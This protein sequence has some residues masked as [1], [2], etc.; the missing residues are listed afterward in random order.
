MG[1]L[2]L[3]LAAATFLI[4]ASAAIPSSAATLFLDVNMTGMPFE[5]ALQANVAQGLCNRGKDCG[6]EACVWL[7]GV[8]EGLPAGSSEANGSAFPGNRFIEWKTGH[9]GGPW[10]SSFGECRACKGLR[11]R[12]L[13]TAA[14][15]AGVAPTPTTFAQLLALA[16]PLLKGRVRYSMDEMH[17]LGPAVTMSGTESALPVTTQH[18]PF[19]ELPLLLDTTGKFADATDATVYTA[20]HLLAKT[21]TSVLAVQ[22][23]TDMP[24]LVDAIVESKMAVFWMHD[25]CSRNQSNVG[26]QAQ[27][28]AMEALL[29]GGHFDKLGL[30][31]MGWF[32]AS[33]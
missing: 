3:L 30:Y 4:T 29:E 21:N 15:T 31:Y 32:S 24:F 18:D 8:G 14:A 16:K 23:P 7:S 26:A 2:V 1:E 5:R 9:G 17:A 20:K 11:G 6:S 25:M 12:W 27:H 28:A 10:Y 19:P 13:A 33:C 22:A